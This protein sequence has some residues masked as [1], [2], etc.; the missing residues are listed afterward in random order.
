[1]PDTQHDPTLPTLE[2]EKQFVEQGKQQ[3]EALDPEANKIQ[4]EFDSCSAPPATPQKKGVTFQTTLN[5]WTLVT[6]KDKMNRLR[7]VKAKERATKLAAQQAAD[8]AAAAAVAEKSVSSASKPSSDTPSTEDKATY[9]ESALQT[10]ASK[11]SEH[12]D[13]V[14]D[15]SSSKENSS[16]SEA[17]GNVSAKSKK[18][19]KTRP[20]ITRPFNT[21]F[22]LKL[23]NKSSKNS[24]KE[25]AKNL[26]TL[27]D[28]LREVDGSLVIY[29]Y[30]DPVPTSAIISK[31]EIPSNITQ[32]KDYF[33]GANPSPREGHVWAS[34]WIGHSE[35][36]ENFKT[37]FKHWSMEN[38]T[39]L[40]KKKLQEK[41]TVRDYFLLYSTDKVDIETLHSAVNTEIKRVTDREYK[42]AF[43]WTV[44]KGKGR[45]VK[46]ET[47]DKKGSQYVKALHVEVPRTEKV[48]T[49]RMLSRILGSS[50]RMKL[51]GRNLR[52]TPVPT[53][54]TPTH[55]KTKIN[56]LIAKQERYLNN[57]ATAVSYDL[58]DIDY[59]IHILNKTLRQM[60][61]DIEQIII[62]LSLY[63]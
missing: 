30:K 5:E 55:Q 10:V 36:I 53:A 14:E 29:K 15:S 8:K 46:N 23:K 16:S 61:M 40:Y 34:V 13:Q 58:Q 44:I 27:F 45:Y 42:F 20:P 26:K 3:T 52:M 22:T 37:N 18:S 28:A 9:A 32:I 56:R 19:K 54:D 49:Y 12:T 31:D 25:L 24:V 47:T 6:P 62:P 35:E 50:S 39:F 2:E 48:A 1:M 59:V 21:Y 41:Q 51:L 38:D 33:S 43:V 60:I 4:A 63:F 17:K 11:K 7:Q 57:I